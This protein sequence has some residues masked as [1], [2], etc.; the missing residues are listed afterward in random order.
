[1][2][3]IGVKILSGIKALAVVIVVM[4]STG[5]AGAEVVKV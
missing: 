1:M 2:I 5:L 4:M 3:K